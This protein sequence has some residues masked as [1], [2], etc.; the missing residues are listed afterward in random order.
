[1]AN[2]LEKKPT[3]V[4]KKEADKTLARINTE[5]Y[6]KP[7]AEKLET[8]TIVYPDGKNKVKVIQEKKYK[9]GVIKRKLRYCGSANKNPYKTKKEK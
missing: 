2:D 4:P 9:N 3:V 5:M 7:V 6:K 8:N 1:M